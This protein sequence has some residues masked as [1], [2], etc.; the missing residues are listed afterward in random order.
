MD[1][2]GPPLNGMSISTFITS[3]D[4]LADN[5]SNNDFGIGPYSNTAGWSTYATSDV[6]FTNFSVGTGYQM[7][8]TS[9][10]NVEFKG[11][12]ATATVDVTITSNETDPWGAGGDTRFN[13]IANP[14][15]SYLNANSNAGTNNVL[16]SNL[17]VLQGGTHQAIWY[18]DGAANSGKWCIWNDN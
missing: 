6:D 7:A 13:L 11:T 5:P 1:L 9:G 3:N 12:L 14:Y 16:S 15:P 10:S 17:N 2:I 4:D 18:W 8:T